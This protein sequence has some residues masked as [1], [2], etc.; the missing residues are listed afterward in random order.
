MVP[1]YNAHLLL[2]PVPC[3]LFPSYGLERRGNH[4]GEPDPVPFPLE[5]M[6]DE[7]VCHRDVLRRHDKPVVSRSARLRLGGEIG[8]VEDALDDTRGV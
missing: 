1:Q 5:D 8:K 3:S 4:V 6:A 2:F 7:P